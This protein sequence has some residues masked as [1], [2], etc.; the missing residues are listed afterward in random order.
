MK[1]DNRNLTFEEI[2]K[3]GEEVI[4]KTLGEISDSKY[5]LNNS[6]NKGGIG[7][8]MEENVFQYKTNSDKNPD[9]T[10][11]GIELKT[12]SIKKNKDGTFSAKERLVLNIINYME[13]YKKTFETSSFWHK[14]KKLYLLF[15]LW[16]ERI[17]RSNYK[18]IKQMLF[19]YPDK[20][21]IIIKQDWEFIINK[22]KEGKADEL[23]EADTLYL[24]ACPKGQNKS[25]LRRQPFSNMPAMQRAYCMK[26]SY[27]THMVRTNVMNEKSEN[28]VSSEDLEKNTFES[29]LY[30]K[31]KKFIGT[32]RE[33]LIDLFKLNHK[34]KDIIER[35]FAGILGIKGKVNNC[36]EFQ[37]ANIVCKTI[38]VGENNLVRESMSFPAFKFMEIINEEWESSTLRTQFSEKKYLFVIFKEENGTYY[39]KGIK[40]WNMPLSVLD[41]N[42]KQVWERTIEIIKSGD[43]V[44]SQKK[45]SSGKLVIFNNF[46]NMSENPVSHVRP[47]AINA[48]DCYNLPIPDRITGLTTYTKQCFWLNSSYI[49]KIILGEQGYV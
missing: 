7:V 3:L 26:I 34:S 8:L 10:R 49:Q 24:G 33:D 25:S 15:Y 17:P 43:I 20:D 36:E 11:A 31:I 48:S 47:H 32:S 4:G 5:N 9:F 30:N 46:P 39:F 41:N 18:I 40:L 45:L 1:K 27:M 12:T 19:E 22:I 23:S 21:L 35:I 16:E 2:E 6:K 44:K 29:S 38:R 42:V 28:I 14:N 37:K 13:E